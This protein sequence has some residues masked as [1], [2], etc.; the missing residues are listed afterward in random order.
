METVHGVAVERIAAEQN[1]LAQSQG[2]DPAGVGAAQCPGEGRRIAAADHGQLGAA[3]TFDRLGQRREKVHVGGI[4]DH[5][6]LA[7]EVAPDADDVRPP[8]L[9]RL[10]DERVD[11]LHHDPLAE[12]TQFDHDH[13]VVSGGTAEGG[14]RQRGEHHE[15]GVE[16]ERGELND[17]VD[18]AEHR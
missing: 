2:V 1:R 5:A 7:R 9:L 4:G 6:A 17:L 13:D 15:F 3:A 12:I 14:L 10:F 16:A 8:E 18:L 11:V